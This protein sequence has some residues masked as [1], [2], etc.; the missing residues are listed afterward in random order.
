[1]IRR[2]GWHSCW[3]LRASSSVVAPPTN[4]WNIG[5]QRSKAVSVNLYLDHTNTFYLPAASGKY[6]LPSVV[7]DRMVWASPGF[8]CFEQ[9][10]GASYGSQQIQSWFIFVVLF[11][12]NDSSNL[13][14]LPSPFTDCT[15]LIGG[16]YLNGFEKAN[17]FNDEIIWR[18]HFSRRID[19]MIVY[20]FDFALPHERDKFGK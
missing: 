8:A 1:M 9:S 17:L 6:L 2:S 5:V 10:N 7:F 14:F 11:I 4:N 12:K 13:S 3:I 20:L 18:G 16:P 19:T 15:F